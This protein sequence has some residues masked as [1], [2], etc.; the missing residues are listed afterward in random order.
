[1][2]DNTKT[3]NI[4]KG[5]IAILLLLCLIDAPYGYY[6]AIRTLVS[7]GF[8]FLAYHYFQCKETKSAII[9]LALLIVFQPLLKISFGRELWTIIDVIVA[10]VLF[11][12]VCKW[13]PNSSKSTSSKAK[14]TQN[15]SPLQSP[16][17]SSSSKSLNDKAN[18]IRSKW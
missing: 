6:Q 14:S 18:D 1:M 16:Q 10:G 17:P 15:K 12:S 8:A 2:G 3:A 9:F 4:V 11:Y 7:F 5:V 13:L